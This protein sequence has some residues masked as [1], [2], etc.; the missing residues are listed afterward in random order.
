MDFNENLWHSPIATFT[1]RILRISFVG[2]LGYE[3]HI[4]NKY[5]GSVYNR[6]MDIGS[7]YE[8]KNAGYRALYS[9]SCEKGLSTLNLSFS[10]LIESI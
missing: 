2:E 10:L 6:V 7:N 1:I 3:L 5:C 4:E 8:L 9:L